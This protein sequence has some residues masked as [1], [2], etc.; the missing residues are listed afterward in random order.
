MQLF[1]GQA[2]FASGRRRKAALSRS[3]V[4]KWR[5]GR[6]RGFKIPRL[7]GRAGSSPALGT[8]R[9]PRIVFQDHFMFLGNC[10]IEVQAYEFQKI[11]IEDRGSPGDFSRTI[12]LFFILFNMI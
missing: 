5:N 9:L 4:P 11:E 6:R 2:C 10:G 3:S 8:K 1:G 12:F 7:R